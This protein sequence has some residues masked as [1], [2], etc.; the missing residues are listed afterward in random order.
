MKAEQQHKKDKLESGEKNQNDLKTGSVID[1]KLALDKSTLI[2]DVSMID[3]NMEKSQHQT[4]S[5][6]RGNEY[7]NLTLTNCE[8]ATRIRNSLENISVPSWYKKY[9]NKCAE[10]NSRWRMARNEDGGWKRNNSMKSLTAL[11]RSPSPSTRSSW[12]SSPSPSR[13][14][15]QSQSQSFTRMSY[16]SKQM[17]MHLNAKS[18]P[19]L[20]PGKQYL[21]WRNINNLQTCENN[22]GEYLQSPTFRLAR[23]CKV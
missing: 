11:S 4:E 18:L 17:R 19:P 10:K 15:V 13:S 14:S 23:T 8:S 7:E 20:P 5:G 22:S 12:T 6:I 3:I 16:D 2:N 1:V 9:E 21:G